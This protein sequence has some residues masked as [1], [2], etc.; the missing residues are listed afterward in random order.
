MHASHLIF[1]ILL[2]TSLA[3]TS[4]AVQQQGDAPPGETLCV[5]T[6]N[7]RY[8]SP[9]PPNSWPQRRPVMKELIEQVAPDLIGTQEGVYPQ[10]KD[11]AADLPQYEW[12][13]LGR[14]GGSR[15]EFMAVFYRKDRFEPLEFDH[16]WLSDT[17][18]VIGSTTWGNKNRRM[19]TWVRFEDRR[20]KKQF[21]FLNTHFDHETPLAREKGAEL[22]VKRMA[23]LK[24]DVPLVLVGDF[25]AAAKA[26]KPYEIITSAGYV[27]AYAAA[28][29]RR[30]ENVGTF[31]NYR[32]AVEGGTRI[33]WILTRVGDTAS[34][35][36]AQ[37]I[38]FSKENQFPSDHFPVAAWLR[39]K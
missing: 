33:D 11:I 31:H 1:G 13:G 20:T 2:F 8:A 24:A 3:E 36:A 22:L 15:G 37:T 9:N 30:G 38:T 17:P 35:D 34:I 12:I 23:A 16:F 39:L 25:N 5:M 19:V 26:S 21:Y 29:E 14:D 10:I 27:D 32:G 6:F 7:L 4:R 28:K 18:E